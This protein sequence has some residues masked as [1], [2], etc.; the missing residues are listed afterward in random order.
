M[1]KGLSEDPSTLTEEQTNAI[2]VYQK[3]HKQ[4]KHKMVD[5]PTF[6]L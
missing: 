6:K 4:N 2:N 5:I 3:F 1:E